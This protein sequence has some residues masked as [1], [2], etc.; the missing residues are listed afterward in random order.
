VALPDVTTGGMRSATPAM[1]LMAVPV[2]GRQLQ[3]SWNQVQGGPVNY[4]I[5]RCPN[6][7]SGIQACGV[8]ASVQSGSY[9]LLQA[10]GVYVVRAV[11]PEGQSQAESNRVQVCCGGALTVW[12]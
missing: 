6:P 3:L 5:R 8:V 11:G 9:R 4:E 7:A 10:D 2:A 12:P 1:S